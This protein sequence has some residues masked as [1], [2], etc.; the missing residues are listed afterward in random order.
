MI[1]DQILDEKCQW[2]FEK[3]DAEQ[4]VLLHL[5][6]KWKKFIFIYY[7]IFYIIYIIKLWI[8]KNSAFFNVFLM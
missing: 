8:V 6:K 3:S 7:I 2:E 4:N 1:E 5:L